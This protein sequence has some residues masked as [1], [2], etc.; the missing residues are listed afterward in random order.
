VKSAAELAALPDDRYLAEMTKC[1]FRSGFVWQVIENNSNRV[2]ITSEPGEAT[3]GPSDFTHG[4]IEFRAQIRENSGA[5]VAAINFREG[6]GYAYT[7]S[8]SEGQLVLGQRESNGPIQAF[9]N[10]AARSLV[11]EKGAWYLIRVEAR[12]PEMIVFVDN[13]RI[14]SASD[15]RLGKGSLSFSVDGGMQVSFDEVNVWELK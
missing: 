11:F 10:E 6:G 9:S 5:G 2:L 8:F 4:I 7:L 12:G 13:N 3:F 15:E 1:V 14:M